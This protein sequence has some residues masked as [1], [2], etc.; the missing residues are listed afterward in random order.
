[1]R[2]ERW[3]RQQL[4]TMADTDEQRLLRAYLTWHL[5]RRLRRRVQVQRRPTS[6][7]QVIGVQTRVRTTIRLLAWLKANRLTLATCRQPDLDR[8]LALPGSRH[9]DDLLRWALRRRHAVGL[10]V[11]QRDWLGPPIDIDSDQRWQLARRLLNDPT[12][13]LVDRVAGLLVLLYA[14][15][16]AAIVRLT[17][18]HVTVGEDGQVRLRLGQAPVLLVEPLAGL[19]VRLVAARKGHATV[20][21]PGTSPWLFPGGRPGRPLS[22][23]RLSVR[24]NRL[25]IAA[26]QHRSAALL[27]LAAELP[28]AVLARLLGVST[29]SAAR[30]QRLAAG[31]WAGYAAQLSRRSGHPSSR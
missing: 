31:D 15:S 4:D 10:Q 16:L 27:Q 7:E 18:D 30:W 12:I 24:L 3:A 28:A 23:K 17:T 1:V 8:W 22:S 9:A 29:D 5:L 14:Q 25:G 19:V 11:P 13:G 2:L 6:P 26:R 21:H 20:G